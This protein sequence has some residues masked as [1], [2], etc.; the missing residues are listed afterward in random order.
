[1]T[2]VAATTRDIIEESISIDGV[3][4]RLFD[5]AGLRE[6]GDAVEKSA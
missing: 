5:T 6:T 4:L 2:E 1:M 3:A